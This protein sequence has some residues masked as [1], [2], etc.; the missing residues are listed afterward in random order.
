[1]VLNASKMSCLQLGTRVWCGQSLQKP[2]ITKPPQCSGYAYGMCWSAGGFKILPKRCWCFPRAFQR[3]VGEVSPRGLP[4]P[5]C[6]WGEQWSRKAQ[7][8]C[9]QDGGLCLQVRFSHPRH[10][11]QKKSLFKATEP[12]KRGLSIYPTLKVSNGYRSLAVTCST[13]VNLETVTRGWRVYFFLKPA[14][15]LSLISHAHPAAGPAAGLPMPW[16][17]S[18]LP[19]GLRGCRPGRRAG[20]GRGGGPGE[21][22]ALRSAGEGRA[23]PVQTSPRPAPKAAGLV[24]HRPDML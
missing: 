6:C 4:C 23:S 10:Q 15:P 14:F 12:R 1:M 8:H 20:P 24:R 11:E 5:A 13:G 7:V 3:G 2:Q 22:A 21:G 16:L 18:P 17:G 19:R 9:W